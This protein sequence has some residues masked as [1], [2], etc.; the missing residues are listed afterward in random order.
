[1]IVIHAIWSPPRDLSWKI[2][3]YRHHAAQPLAAAGCS[4][5]PLRFAAQVKRK[6]L[7]GAQGNKRLYFPL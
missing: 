3:K 6:P 5:A 7:G 2:K 1:T 4:L